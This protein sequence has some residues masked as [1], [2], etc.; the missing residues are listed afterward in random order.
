MTMLGRHPALAAGLVIGP[1]MALAS[2]LGGGSVLGAA[3]SLAIVIGYALIVSLLARRGDAFAILAGTPEDE[4]GGHQNE[5]ASTWAFGITAIVALGGLAV[6]QATGG[7]W[8]P[9]ALICVV[10]AVA[11]AGSLLVLRLRS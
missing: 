10:M 6:A 5:V 4:R 9:Y 3:V 8:T 7:S 1:V 11:Y 2:L